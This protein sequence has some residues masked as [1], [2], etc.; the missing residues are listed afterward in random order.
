VA[1]GC[2]RVLA[3]GEGW[4]E[5]VGRT[6]EYFL[7]RAEQ[8]RY[9]AFREAGYPLGSGTVESACKG[10]GHRCKG[11][12]Q[13]WK[14]KGLVAILALRSAGMGGAKE[15]SWAWEQMRQAA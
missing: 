1:A 5:S 6:A 14:R 9:P 4:S 11:R 8:M 3:L 2:A 7:E 15:W 12:G 10:I 13:R